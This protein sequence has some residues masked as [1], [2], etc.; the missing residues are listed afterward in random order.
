MLKSECEKAKADLTEALCVASISLS[1]R[2]GLQIIPRMLF[3]N[4]SEEEDSD[5]WWGSSD[6]LMEASG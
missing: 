6:P 5:T 1:Q 4:C 3:G 2:G